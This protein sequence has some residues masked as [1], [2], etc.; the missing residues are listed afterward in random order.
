MIR[1]TDYTYDIP[2]EDLQRYRRLSPEEIL[3]WLEEYNQFIRAVTEKS[4]PT[5]GQA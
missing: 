1:P 2:L 3:R 5:R 4:G